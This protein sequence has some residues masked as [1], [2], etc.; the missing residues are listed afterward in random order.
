IVGVQRAHR[1]I[2]AGIHGLE[3]IKR[4]RSTDLADDDAFGPH[5]QA[6]THKIAHRDLALTLEVGRAGLQPYDVRLPELQL[7]RGFARHDALVPV[8][9]TCQ[10][11]QQGRLA[12]TRAARDQNIAAHP[13][14]NPEDIRARWRDSAQIDELI[15]RELVLLKLTDRE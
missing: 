9:I 15:E 1:A 11:I 3:K 8:D 7:A 6:I 5:S 14:D 12:G 13:A 4:L 2:M 10:A